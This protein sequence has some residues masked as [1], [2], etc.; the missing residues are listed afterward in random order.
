MAC[1][2][3]E[4]DYPRP[5]CSI[6]SDNEFQGF[7]IRL[8]DVNGNNLNLEQE[9]VEFVFEAYQGGY[10]FMSASSLEGTISVVGETA[11]VLPIVLKK[12]IGGTFRYRVKANFPNEAPVTGQIGKITVKNQ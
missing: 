12:N 3:A 6:F 2:V 9:G 5:G 10:P 7:L 1:S 11:D 4:I 8:A